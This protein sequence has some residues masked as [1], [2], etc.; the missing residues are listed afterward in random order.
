MP[1]SKK[2]DKFFLSRT[3]TG[4]RNLG[5]RLIGANGSYE[6]DLSNLSLQELLDFLKK[7]D[8]NPASV[9]LSSGFCFW[10]KD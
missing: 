10:I 5:T 8:V 7:N 1:R 3:P 2:T 4:Y 9:G 6:G